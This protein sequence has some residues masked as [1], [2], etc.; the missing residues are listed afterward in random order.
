MSA[1]FDA[2]SAREIANRY[3]RVLDISPNLSSYPSIVYSAVQA[4]LS[5]TEVSNAGGFVSSQDVIMRVRAARAS[6]ARIGLTDQERALAS[7][8]GEVT[9]DV[10]ADI[11][12]DTLSYAQ[13]STE[14]TAEAED[15]GWFGSAVNF[16]ADK[17]GDLG[18]S[19]VNAPVISHTLK[20]LA[21]GYEKALTP[22][23]YATAAGKQ[24]FDQVFGDN[25]TKEFYREE[26]I[27]AGYDP[28]SVVS[29]IAFF[30]HGNQV[31]SDLTP[32]REQYGTDAVAFARQVAAAAGPYAGAADAAR[33]YLSSLGSSSPDDIAAAFERT[34][35]PE[36]AELY[37]RLGDYHSSLGRDLARVVVYEG[38]EPFQWV[39]G[40]LDAAVA[41]FA[42][43]FLIGVRVGQKVQV[44]RRGIGS[45]ADQ[46]RIREIMSPTVGQKNV[47]E[48]WQTFLDDATRLRE[49]K[50]SGDG[51]EQASVFAR[52]NAR[53]PWAMK[54]LPEINGQRMLVGDPFK[55]VEAA[56][57]GTVVQNRV[58]ASFYQGKPITT[59][60]ELTEYMV[61]T[62]ALVRMSAGMAAERSV[63]MPGV[64]SRWAEVKGATA[65]RRTARGLS[66]G[67]FIDHTDPA[68]NIPVDGD[69]LARLAGEASYEYN[70]TL[71][72]RFNVR[73]KRLSSLLPENNSYAYNDTEAVTAVKRY[74]QV[75]MPKPEA[76]LLAARF[77]LGT[78][79]ERRAIQEAV[80]EQSFHAA[81]LGRSTLGLKFIKE[82]RE[83]RSIMVNRKYG[84]A[85]TDI[86]RDS[87]HQGG[88]R[89]VAVHENQLEDALHIPDFKGM[90]WLAS[91]GSTAGKFHR[92]IL[93]SQGMDTFLAVV[94]MGW[95][96]RAATGARAGLEETVGAMFSGQFGSMV[97]L[98]GELTRRHI[99]FTGKGNEAFKARVAE[100]YREKAVDVV[101]TL[102]GSALSKVAYYGSPR[103]REMAARLEGAGGVD[104]VMAELAVRELEDAARYV[105]VTGVSLTHMNDG[106]MGYSAAADAAGRRG[107]PGS[108]YRLKGYGE[109][110]LGDG[111]QGAA[112]WADNLG[113]AFNGN[114]VSEAA[115]RGLAAGD[116]HATTV[117]NVLAA[118]KSD[119]LSSFRERAEIVNTTASGAKATTPEMRELALAE[120]AERVVRD[121]E[122]RVRGRGGDFHTELVQRLANGDIPSAHWIEKNVDEALRPEHAIGKLWAEV[123]PGLKDGGYGIVPGITQLFAKGYDLFVTRQVSWLTRQPMYAGN[124]LVARANLAG[125]EKMLVDAGISAETARK[126]TITQAGQHAAHYTLA[127]VDNPRVRSQFSMTVRNFWM[128]E[129][130]TEDFGRRWYRMIKEDPAIVRKA[131]MAVESGIHS[132]VLDYN[133][134]GDL[135]ITY[136]ASGAVTNALLDFGE[137]LGLDGLAQIPVQGDM[138]SQLTFLNPALQNPVGFSTSPV[139]STSMKALSAIM[140]E[141]TQLNAQAIDR[142]ANGELGAGRPWYE[143][144]MP[145][146]VAAVWKTFNEDG[147]Q[148]ASAQRNA[149]VSLDAG[150]Y[151]EKF[152]GPDV[153]AHDRE[154][155]LDS[156]RAQTRNQMALRGI[157]AFFAP[158]SPTTPE[159]D[160]GSETEA[161]VLYRAAGIHSLKDEMRVMIDDYGYE[162]ALAVWAKV[163]PNELAFFTPGTEVGTGA[164]APIT[165]EAT[166]WMGNNA[167]LFEDYSEVAAY[168]IPNAPGE[169][170][171]VAYN[172]QL[173]IGVR[174]KK[175]LEQFAD[176]VLVRNSTNE[177][178]AAKDAADKAINDAKASG[179]TEY[180][181]Q[182][183]ESFS[184]WKKDFNATH[185]V[186]VE[187]QNLY[188]ERANRRTQAVAE[189]SQ[190]LANEDVSGIPDAPGAAAMLQAYETYQQ[191]QLSMSGDQST[192]ARVYKAQAAQSYRAYMLSVVAQYPGLIDLY[193]SVFVGLD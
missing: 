41:W 16:V 106:Q 135:I 185:P 36:F 148:F 93:Q 28:D 6:G 62:N 170:S 162:K 44:S 54:L 63:L 9:A 38:S 66:S 101:G 84:F 22:V 29:V 48:G 51:V 68:R 15:L 55:P 180:A 136:P 114:G 190:L 96:I 78:A 146:P 153:T 186:F 160:Y 104:D 122:K 124:Y 79:A 35:T 2:E 97:Y 74:A 50:A 5:D 64:V 90:L 45:M 80:V 105:E 157:F 109:K 138:T 166:N 115:L 139:I 152:R 161:D 189:L 69:D 75:F 26:I 56:D 94:K 23:R 184:A 57:A 183:E 99:K 168:F 156:V 86:I 181:K 142:L 155:L 167:R 60:D 95:L 21:Y 47:R 65:E 92:G 73:A 19:I 132:G 121:I 71:R 98:R 17:A 83:N 102:V 53:T 169:F 171:Q 20:G 31:Y 110:D 192:D 81:G 149:I 10:D 8:S 13:P 118:L 159:D 182:I 131:Q 140:P 163:H 175:S 25:S 178:Y 108:P 193:N 147:A 127:R 59:L 87:A 37:A 58:S 14:E 24:G 67:R 134:E 112:D 130:A 111:G 125:Y 3:Q 137:T 187:Q 191:F 120:H 107:I 76:N 82:Y 145:A 85:E 158:A 116:D 11:L 70:K 89:A 174:S 42:D 100:N 49:A 165:L 40:S 4:N 34:N 33:A 188:G 143:T 39:S 123:A 43:P 18:K 88:R 77:E 173:A 1:P 164:D 144:W 72:G 61:G 177:Y 12:S 46:A 141:S 133:S 103:A 154:V 27:G 91:K 151:L 128:F 117:A 30:S 172:A 126:M 176:Q 150:G 7:A 129:R 32:L 52:M 179:N 119:R 113:Q